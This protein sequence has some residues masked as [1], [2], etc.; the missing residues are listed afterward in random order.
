MVLEFHAWNNH[1]FVPRFWNAWNNH[2]FVP[3]FHAPTYR[4]Q[5]HRCQIRAFQEITRTF[6]ILPNI[7]SLH[8]CLWHVDHMGPNHKSKGLKGRLAGPTP[9][10]TSHTLSRFKPRL[11]GYVH[12]LVHKSIP[13]LRVGGNREEWP[14]GHVDGRPTV[15]HLQTDSIK[16]VEAPLDL[17]VR[18]LTKELTHIILFL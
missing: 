2:V 18:I 7:V 6:G 10:P 11:G 17:Y 4:F 12:T 9:W 13:C 14:A 15:H 5:E 16:L 3:G 1:V 8:E